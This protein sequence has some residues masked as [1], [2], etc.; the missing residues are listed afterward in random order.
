MSRDRLI[1]SAALPLVLLA[2]SLPSFAQSGDPAMC[3]PGVRRLLQGD[4]AGAMRDLAPVA[5]SSSEDLGE[6]AVNVRAIAK[7]MA[8]DDAGAL[9]DLEGAVAADP[10]SPLLRYNRGMALLALGEW[11]RAAADFDVVAAN[12]STDLN[13]RA[14]YHRALVDLRLRQLPEAEKQL[15]RALHLDPL[16]PEA[17]V[18]LGWVLERQKRWAEA[19][20][21]YKA[22]VADHPGA[23][24]AMVRFGVVALRAGFPDTARTWL[25]RAEQADPSSR[26]AV[27]ARKYLVMLE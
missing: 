13:A 7:L 23:T 15:R 3:H 24:W 22:F 18:L 16:L 26:E 9:A 6:H 11:D 1:R 19:G 8:G 4:V 25:R 17:R 21:E 2:L 27:E 10:A 20:E 12:E 14:A 5:G